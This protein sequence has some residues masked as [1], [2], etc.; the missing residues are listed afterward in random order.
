MGIDASK[1][2]IQFATETARLSDYK[3]AA[4]IEGGDHTVKQLEENSFDGVILSNVLDVMPKD[5]SKAG[6]DE[7]P[8]RLPK[9][10]KVC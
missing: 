2:G 8:V 4:F 3:T 6:G 10:V 1:A 5:V 9:P 7:S